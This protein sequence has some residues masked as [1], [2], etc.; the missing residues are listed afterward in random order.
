MLVIKRN[1][2]RQPYQS[3]K[4]E[5]SIGIA[6]KG[7]G[8]DAEVAS[9]ASGISAR[10]EGELRG[11]ALVTTQQI[12]AETLKAL[13]GRDELAYLRYASAVKRYRSLDDFWLDA[14]ALM[15]VVN[16]DS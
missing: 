12:A 8:S 16:G 13:K 4:L 9:L 1:G 14:L 15:D 7:R 3:K 11:Q 6:A 2:V 10:V 5:L